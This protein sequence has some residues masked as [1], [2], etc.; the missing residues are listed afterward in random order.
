MKIFANLALVAPG[1]L[2]SKVVVTVEDGRIIGL[3]GGA[4]EGSDS[5]VEFLIP[6]ACNG[7]SHAFHR[8]LRGRAIQG[9]DDFWSW[10]EAMYRLAERLNP[11]TYLELATLV[12]QEMRLG[13]FT[14]VGEFHYLHRS[15]NGQNYS[16]Q[17]AMGRA[18][19]EAAR[20][21]Q[22][23]LGLIDVAY[24]HGGFGNRGYLPLEG[25]QRRFG[26]TDVEA[27]LAR[28]GEL[29]DTAT[30][31]IVHGAHSLRAVSLSELATV[32]DAIAG[33]PW[34]LHLMEQAKEVDEVVAYYGERPLRLLEDRGLISPSTTLVHLNQLIEFELACLVR[35]GAVTCACPSTEEDLGDGLSPAGQILQAGAR[36]SV[37]TDQHVH[38]DAL[39][40]ASRIDAH[41]RLRTHQRSLV[42]V[43]NLWPTL[44]AHDTIG[45]GEAGRIEPG[46]VA[47]L[48]ALDLGEPGVAGA[49]P[50][51]LVRLGT[52]AAISKVWVDGRE[53]TS[54]IEEERRELGARLRETIAKLEG[55]Y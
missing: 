26:D 23:R 25:P 6:G 28:V 19:I 11:D 3:E 49:D 36:V 44:W 51:E 8:G 9:A 17:N 37:G 7:H 4:P 35:T 54:D 10:R 33:A 32:V 45:F 5:V 46:A 53:T 16:D 39:F 20:L 22:V 15:A 31:R 27:Y 30:L 48:V 24:L 12:F 47:D 52:R 14:S 18:L 50:S 40:E 55:K 21:A 2:R 34:H 29:T 13:G 38:I 42:G 41:E 43:D 1:D